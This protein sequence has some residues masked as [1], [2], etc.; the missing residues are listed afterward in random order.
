MYTTEQLLLF[1]LRVVERDKVIDKVILGLHIY[2][3]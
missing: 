1:V 3:K 2:A